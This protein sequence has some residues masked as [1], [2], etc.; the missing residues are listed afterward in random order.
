MQIK[1][2]WKYFTEWLDTLRFIKL[3]YYKIAKYYAVS[4]IIDPKSHPIYLQIAK[5][6]NIVAVRVHSLIFAL[7]SS[8]FFH[9]LEYGL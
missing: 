3:L 2:E 8:F 5:Y 1:V 6:G 9:I 7:V 4:W